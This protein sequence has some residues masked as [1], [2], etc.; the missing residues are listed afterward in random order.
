MRRPTEQPRCSERA[1][2]FWRETGLDPIGIHECRHTCASALIASSINAKSLSTFLGH[3]SI[4]ITFDLDGHV[5]PGGEDEAVS[6]LD[7][8]DERKLSRTPAR[9]A[10]TA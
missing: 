3:G 4:A 8:Y 5:M 7:A 2:R 1:R 10:E 6:L 9:E